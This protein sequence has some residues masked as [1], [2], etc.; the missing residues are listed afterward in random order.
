MRDLLLAMGLVLENAT[1]LHLPGTGLG[2][3]ELILIGWVAMT[4]AGWA[5]RLVPEWSP[6]LSRLVVFWLVFAFAQ[7]IGLLVG[8]ATEDFREFVIGSPHLD[9]IRADGDDVAFSSS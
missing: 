5:R 1:Q 6:A 9:R 7:S 3:G 8:L 2:V 4:L